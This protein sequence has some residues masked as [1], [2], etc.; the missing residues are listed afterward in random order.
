MTPSPGGLRRD[1]KSPLSSPRISSELIIDYY[2]FIKKNPFGQ[3]NPKGFFYCG[4]TVN[5][6]RFPEGG[7]QPNHFLSALLH[8][9]FGRA[10]PKVLQKKDFCKK[11]KS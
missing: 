9:R 10:S 5:Q 4:K 1:Y 7:F 3:I 11:L 2:V 8:S 6:G